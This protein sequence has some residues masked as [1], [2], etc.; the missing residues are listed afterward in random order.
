MQPDAE[1][2]HPELVDLLSWCLHYAR[3]F[4]RFQR[5]T[6][7]GE[8]P[9]QGFEIAVPVVAPAEFLFPGKPPDDQHSGLVLRRIL[10]HPHQGLVVRHRRLPGPAP[11]VPPAVP[12]EAASNGDACWVVNA[13][14][15]E[16]G[17]RW[18]AVTLAAQAT[19]PPLS[20][21][22]APHLS[23][24]DFFSRKPS[25]DPCI[26][27]L[28]P[29]AQEAFRRTVSPDGYLR[30]VRA[31]G[32]LH[33]RTAMTALAQMQALWSPD[34]RRAL[35]HAL[36]PSQA[37][38]RY[39]TPRQPRLARYRRQAV[40]TFPSLPWNR[41]PTSGD[42]AAFRAAIDAARSPLPHFP[43]SIAFRSPRKLLRASEHFLAAA[44]ATE[45][46]P[47]DM[48]HKSPW[49]L[50]PDEQR[51]VAEVIE[52]TPEPWW[53]A[54]DD[55]VGWAVFC[56]LGP[57]LGKA[58]EGSGYVSLPA[59]VDRPFPGLRRVLEGYTGEWEQLAAHPYFRDSHAT[60]RVL[61]RLADIAHDL[62]PFLE[63]L[64]RRL[65]HATNQ[66]L[67][68]VADRSAS[69]VTWLRRSDAW[70]RA[71]VALTRQRLEASDA[72]SQEEPEDLLWPGLLPERQLAILVGSAQIHFSELMG[73]RALLTEGARMNHCLGGYSW[74]D[75]RR[76]GRFLA[77][78]SLPDGERSTVH[79]MICPKESAPDQAV[80][81]RQHAG[82]DNNPPPR[83]HEQ[84]VE[85][86]LRRLR[87][88]PDLHRRLRRIT[89]RLSD[90]LD[91]YGPQLPDAGHLGIAECCVN[92]PLPELWQRF[93]HCLPGSLRGALRAAIAPTPPSVDSGR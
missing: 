73:P 31:V 68:C 56:A 63:R 77:V 10:I 88:E 75:Y 3:W 8:I 47:W 46:R 53:P 32:R 30:I 69:L 70:H 11:E 41:L 59:L 27:R 23:A 37:L 76:G 89:D 34:L 91:G 1:G 38:L 33:L 16:R 83:S 62:L 20:M 49:N 82:F 93:R 6:R 86:L 5:R 74:E 51:L 13:I 7:P 26:E 57:E 81:I 71:V 78:E 58:T 67:P 66:P 12:A 48:D 90:A 65:E 79:V 2:P 61:A 35:D 4:R 84:A 21:A 55:Q 39:L 42:W 22:M 64:R 17:A 28:S 52:G 14:A 43:R 85:E 29:D 54:G 15:A 25:R 92:A 9:W 60:A 36:S 24:R 45:T 50:P 44:M 72:E 18:Y 19:V 80:T 40:V 87:D